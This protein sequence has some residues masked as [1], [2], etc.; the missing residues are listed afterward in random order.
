M[1]STYFGNP[2]GGSRPLI[3]SNLRNRRFPMLAVLDAAVGHIG[4]IGRIR[5]LGRRLS[6]L[7]TTISPVAP[8]GRS[9]LRS[10]FSVLQGAP[11]PLAVT[12]PPRRR[13]GLQP[14]GLLQ[15]SKPPS[16]HLGA[17]DFAFFSRKKRVYFHFTLQCTW[18]KDTP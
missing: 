11:A 16:F 17:I 9:V 10:L 3:G 18:Q 5:R 4:P 1:I 13:P 12:S 7:C 15:A 2:A 8:Q 14:P 6:P